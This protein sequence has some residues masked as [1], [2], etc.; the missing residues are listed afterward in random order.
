MQKL[1]T[2]IKEIEFPVQA[3]GTLS[4]PPLFGGHLFLGSTTVIGFI[5]YWRMIECEELSL[6]INIC[7]AKTYF[8]F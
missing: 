5:Q 2:V 7:L 6:L 3:R 4:A 1:N 8:F